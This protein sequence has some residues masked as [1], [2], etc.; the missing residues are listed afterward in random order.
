MDA[1]MFDHIG[2]VVKKLEASKALYFTALKAIGY[3]LLQ[4]NSSDGVGWL[5]FGKDQ[6]S[7]FFV[8][9]AGRP[10]FW[11]DNHDASRSPIHCAFSA[12]SEHC[13]NEFHSLG[14]Q[15]GA[16]D[17]GAPG[18]RGH[19]YYAGYLID[20]DGNNIEAGFRKSVK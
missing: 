6:G 4:D 18:D 5:V 12:P 14:L 16:A 8:V 9:S 7:P 10:S 19:G 11:G 2:I 20:L 13:V 1:E 17:N 3:E 15:H